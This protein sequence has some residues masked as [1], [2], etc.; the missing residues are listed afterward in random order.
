MKRLLSIA[1]LA[2]SLLACETPRTVVTGSW[3]APKQNKSYHSIVVAALNNHA[4]TRSTIENEMA[5]ALS[6]SGIKAVKGIDEFPPNLNSSDTSRQALMNKLRGSGTDAILT[7]SIVNKET[8]TRYVPGTFW[9]YYSYW[10]P[11][12]YDPGYYTT[13]RQYYLETNLY[14]AATEDLVWSA[15]SITY[16]PLNLPAFAKE[17]AGITIAKMKQDGVLDST[18]DK[19]TSAR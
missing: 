12:M 14:D 16:D 10:H 3:K 8:D 2:V 7:V 5:S 9:G 11:F 19:K 15:Q 1:V 6:S 4:V 13:D 18:P 17:F